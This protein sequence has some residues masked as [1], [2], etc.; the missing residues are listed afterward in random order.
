M[1]LGCDPR[2]RRI[3]V[4]GTG[5][6]GACLAWL[7]ARE[8]FAVTVV[9]ADR[10]A[11][12][13]TALAAG[14]VHGLGPPGTLETWLSMDGE[15]LAG[16]RRRSR[17][18]HLLLRELLMGASRRLGYSLRPHHL[19]VPC[20]QRGATVRSLVRGLSAVGYPV[21]LR[22]GAEGFSLCRSRDALVGSRALTFELLR[23]ARRHDAHI[24]LGVAL[25]DGIRTGPSGMRVVIEG[26]SVRFDRVLWSRAGPLPGKRQTTAFRRRMILQQIFESGPQRLRS[27]LEVNGDLLLA[28]CLRSD[29]VILRR[30][31]RPALRGGMDWPKLPA[32]WARYCGSVR[33]QRLLEPVVGAPAVSS[34][35]L[36]SLSGISAWPITALFGACEEAVRGE[37]ARH[38]GRK[39]G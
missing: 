4:V 2:G 31:A 16:A 17:R 28:P 39:L 26:A 23:Q 21:E 9:S 15:E 24:R 6:T 3:L 29:G 5:L 11:S 7:A 34:P 38:A 14:V 27:I 37:D 8:G 33:R 1:N 36:V 32:S 25:C 10:P 30:Q 18:G 35:Y 13:T 20:A 22:E 12:Q 19:V